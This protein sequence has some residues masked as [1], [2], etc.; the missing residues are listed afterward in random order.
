MRFVTKVT[1]TGLL[2]TAPLLASGDSGFAQY[3]C[4]FLTLE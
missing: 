4:G 3:N 1:A 2:V